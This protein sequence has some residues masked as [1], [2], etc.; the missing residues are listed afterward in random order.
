MPG[1]CLYR[2]DDVSVRVHGTVQIQGSDDGSPRNDEEILVIPREGMFQSSACVDTTDTGSWKYSPG[3]RQLRLETPVDVRK[4]IVTLTE[5]LLH[6][7]CQ[8]GYEGFRS[9]R[10]KNKMSELDRMKR[11]KELTRRT[12]EYWTS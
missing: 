12:R 10:D 9:D 6:I 5:E 7:I 3:G 2:Y 4:A 1:P 11:M 8:G